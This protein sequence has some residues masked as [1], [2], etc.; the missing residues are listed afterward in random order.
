VIDLHVH[1]SFSDGSES[2][3]ALAELAAAAGLSAM[4]L[5]D[6]DTTA[7]I[8]EA[9]VAFAERNIEL[10]VGCE[11]SLKDRGHDIVADDGSITHPS[12]HVLAYFVPEDPA[13]PLQQLLSGL[14]DDRET[15]NAR[16][17][18]TLHELGYTQL[19]WDDLMQRAGGKNLGRPHFAAAILANYADELAG[20]TAEEKTRTIFTDILGDSGSAYISKAHL[21]VTDVVAAAGPDVVLSIAH[22]LFNYGSRDLSSSTVLKEIVPTLERLRGEGLRGVECWYGQFDDRTR[23]EMAAITRGL[24]MVPTGGSDFHG[25]YKPDVTFAK[26]RF[27]DLSVSDNVLFELRELVGK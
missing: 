10:V 9:R 6:H 26:G 27:N 1:S 11:V 15:R 7:G 2:P 25:S 16:L 5:T 18:T 20:V 17:F 22:P 19:T 8:A 12:I 21:T 4:A 13:H 23:H 3:T 14:Q 24:G